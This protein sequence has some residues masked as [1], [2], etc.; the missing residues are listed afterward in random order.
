[1]LLLRYFIVVYYNQYFYSFKL[2][3]ML[4]NVVRTW[5]IVKHDVII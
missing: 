5:R 1:M 4:S 3:A 2:S